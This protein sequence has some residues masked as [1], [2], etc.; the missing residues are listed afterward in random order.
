MTHRFFVPPA[1]I[2]GDRVAFDAAIA[3]QLRH[4]LRLRPGA[5]VIVLDNA[6]SAYEV[7]LETVERD[8]AVGR[9]T[10]RRAAEGEARV[11]VT[12]YQS[13]IKRAR[14]E[15]LLQKGTELGVAR[16]VPTY[17]RRTVAGG[18]RLG[19]AKRTRWE[20][21][22][23]EAAEQCRR[24][25]LPDLAPPMSLADACHESVR[26]HDLAI[27]PW[28]EQAGHG[29]ASVL[30]G[31]TAPLDSVALLI[32]PEGGFDADEVQLARARGVHVVTLG[33]RILRAET[34]GVVAASV[35]LYELGGLG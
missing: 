1:S 4:V 6:G 32:G 15:W 2:T 28:E 20:R 26:A 12:L 30:R 8:T 14:F 13:M 9:I 3:H 16:F 11:R 18:T 7:V 27:L 17:S 31:R 5:R 22:I 24:G 29:L 34:A 25:R 35:V 33:P 23:R 10:A 19:E 21:I